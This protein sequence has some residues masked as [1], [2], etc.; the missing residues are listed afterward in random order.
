VL[1]VS[2]TT[3]IAAGAQPLTVSEISWT[4]ASESDEWI[5]LANTSGAALDLA[6]TPF[7]LRFGTEITD[8]S[9]IIGGLGAPT[10]DVDE[11]LIVR[12][13]GATVLDLA[14]P[15]LEV[16]EPA[17]P[18]PAFSDSS[19]YLQL[20]DGADVLI[21][22]VQAARPDTVNLAT[23]TLERLL[24]DTSGTLDS[25]WASAQVIGPRYVSGTATV[26]GTPGMVRA[27]IAAPE[28]IVLN[29]VALAES[30]DE[31]T[32]AAIDISATLNST[33]NSVSVWA[34]NLTTGEVSYSLSTTAGAEE[35]ADIITLLPG[36]YQFSVLVGDAAGNLLPVISVPVETALD[37]AFVVTPEVSTLE[38]PLVAST[39]VATTDTVLALD[40]MTPFG[41]VYDEVLVIRNGVLYTV[42][43]PALDGTITASLD[44][45]ANQVNEFDLVAGVA[46]SPTAMTYSAPVR[47]SVVQDTLALPLSGPTSTV[48]A[49]NPGTQDV[50]SGLAG[51]AEPGAIVRV[52]SDLAFTKVIGFAI[53]KADGSFGPIMIGDNA[54]A[55]VYAMQIDVLGN[56]S[57]ITAFANAVAFSLPAGFALTQG[58]TGESEV[59]LSWQTVPGAVGY[60]LFVRTADGAYTTAR[61][62]CSVGV[63]CQTSAT[64]LG[65]TADRGYVAGLVAIDAAGNRTVMRELAFRTATP[66]IAPVTTDVEVLQTAVTTTGTSTRVIPSPTPAPTV[67][68]SEPTPEP[69]EGEVQSATTEAAANWA[70]WIILAIILV[71][72]LAAAL[73]Y[74][75]WFGG[76]AG[77]AAMLAAAKRSSDEKEVKPADS[78]DS[79]KKRNT[80]PDKRW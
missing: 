67:V 60:E 39:P 65:L 71:I 21:D 30:A 52:A 45:L 38:A 62:L 73:G 70:P 56:T 1:A 26:L 27:T 50:F 9:V 22:E 18:L 10:L 59:T 6:S 44:L 51:A 15:L 58:A 25:N 5:E 31:A 41:V 61:V 69:E 75:Y 42:L 35:Y 76:E 72:A 7:V 3:I 29:P 14:N 55:T 53:A 80:P 23:P 49:N 33:I 8:P 13:S 64:L 40:A 74:F 46:S 66:V 4:G 36:R 2:P 24:L 47:I 79:T 63:P 16:F 32:Q 11:R 37:G 57:S 43:T 20:R 19:L 78:T 68:A 54:Y 48:T 28:D 17:T 34:R 12:N 77:E